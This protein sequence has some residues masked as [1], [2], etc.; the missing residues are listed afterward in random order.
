MTRYNFFTKVFLICSVCFL[1]NS[2]NPF[3]AEAFSFVNPFTAVKKLV[4]EQQA[5]T[6]YNNKN[7][8]DAFKNYQKAADAGSPW[9]QFMLANMYLKG[10]YVKKNMKKHLYW[11]RKAA[12]NGSPSAC[13]LLGRGY[14]GEDNSRAVSYL[15]KAAD[16]EH[17]SAMYLLGLMYATG[18]G[19]SKDTKNALKWFRLAKAHGMPVDD[20]WLSVKGIEKSLK[21]KRVDKQRFQ[22][23]REIQRRLNKLGYNPGPSDGLYGKKTKDAIQAFQKKNNLKPDGLASVDLLNS[24]K[25]LAQ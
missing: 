13:F 9:S 17:A 5:D 14:L 3:Y 16:K 21:L 15:K 19:V 22:L 12:D 2:L 10:D 20:K 8:A 4:S 24:L 7:Y 11:L 18:N 6:A 1:L 23:V 25:Q